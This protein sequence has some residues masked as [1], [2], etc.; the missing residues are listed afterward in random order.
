MIDAAANPQSLLLLGGTSD[1]ALKIGGARHRPP[2]AGGA[3][4][5]PH[6]ARRGEAAAELD[7]AGLRGDRGRSGGTFSWRRTRPPS[8]RPSPV[9][10][11]TS[12][13][14]P[15]VCSAMPSAVGPTLRPRWNWSRSTTPLRSTSKCCWPIGCGP[16]ATAGSLLCPA[17]RASGSVAP[18]SRTDRPKPVSTASI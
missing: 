14:S 13:S 18:T 16:R 7:R 5:A 3:R 6:P 10:T 2:A 12:R 15:S 8:T 11:S 1:I 9:V 4:C 17:R